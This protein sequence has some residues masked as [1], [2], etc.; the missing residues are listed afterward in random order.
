MVKG[1]DVF[2]L[3][4]RTKTETDAGIIPGAKLIP[5]D[6]LE[7]RIREVPRAVEEEDPRLLRRRRTLRRRRASSSPARDTT[8]LFNLTGGFMSWKRSDRE[9]RSKT[10]RAGGAT[11]VGSRPHDSRRDRTRPDLRRECGLVLPV[12]A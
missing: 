10:G 4:V 11:A 2:V 12:N 7:E 5:V 9:A 8:G 6:E 3:D 1:P